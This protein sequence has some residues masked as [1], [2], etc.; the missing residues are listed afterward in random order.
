[1]IFVIFR[2]FFLDADTGTRTHLF[3]M[4][5]TC[6][7]AVVAIGLLALI[8]LHAVR[9]RRE[10]RQILIKLHN[11]LGDPYSEAA[12]LRAMKST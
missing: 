11:R 1:M 8:A 3:A 6:S 10:R 12:Y 5:W 7:L 9:R 4:L 2:K